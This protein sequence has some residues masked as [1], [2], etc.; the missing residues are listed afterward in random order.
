MSAAGLASTRVVIRGT[1]P[2]P[3]TNSNTSNEDNNN[4]GL[5]RNIV[6]Y[7][8]RNERKNTTQEGKRD[9]MNNTWGRK[10]EKIQSNFYGILVDE[11]YIPFFDPIL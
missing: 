4:G 6:G 2:P 1:V 5:W 7:R 11:N 9:R 8:N 3:H 10:D